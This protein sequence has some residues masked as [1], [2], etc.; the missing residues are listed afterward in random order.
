MPKKVWKYFILSA[1]LL[2]IYIGYASI[3][4]ID[5]K[6][7]KT[8][9]DPW[10][11]I[12]IFI[13]IW[14]PIYAYF[15]NKDD[16]PS[17]KSSS[18]KDNEAASG[19]WDSFKPGSV[20]EPSAKKPKEP[21][22]TPSYK[23]DP[24]FENSGNKGGYSKPNRAA[25]FEPQKES[26]YTQKSH[27]EKSSKN[28]PPGSNQTNRTDKSIA[29]SYK[30]NERFLE[31]TLK[32]K[33]PIVVPPLFR[34]QFIELKKSKE[35]VVKGVTEKKFI[36]FLGRFFPNRVSQEGELEVPGT[37][38][39]RVYSPDAILRFGEINIVI[40]IDE[41]YVGSTRRPTHCINSYDVDRNKVFSE[42][43]WMVVRFAEEQIV[44]QPDECIFFLVD[45]ISTI[46][47]NLWFTPTSMSWPSLVPQWTMAQAEKMAKEGYREKYLG[48]TFTPKE[49]APPKEIEYDPNSD[50]NEKPKSN[51]PNETKF[52]PRDTQPKKE[53]PKPAVKPKSQAKS[54][55]PIYENKD[56]ANPIRPTYSPPNYGNRKPSDKPSSPGNVSGKKSDDSVE[57]K[58]RNAIANGYFLSFTYNRKVGTIKP[59]KSISEEGTVYLYGN[60]FTSNEVRKFKVKKIQT[61]SMKVLRNGSQK[62]TNKDP[63]KMNRLIKRA[64]NFEC[65]ATIVYQKDGEQKTYELSHIDKSDK[66]NNCISGQF[67]RGTYDITL[68]IRKIILMEIIYTSHLY[69][70]YPSF[71]HPKSYSE[72]PKV[73]PT[74]TP[75]PSARRTYK[76]PSS[77]SGCMVFLIV[78][79]S[80]IISLLYLLF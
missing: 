54:S 53:E 69:S 30:V 17:S 80:G 29:I 33:Y 5:F 13:L 47:S 14:I 59:T 65:V 25:S 43:G 60:E 62:C 18:G 67:L 68:S 73:T 56:T 28:K 3:F 20:A 41:P 31:G 46:D 10:I 74:P 27:P 40:E 9:N 44:K 24:K 71:G 8:Y 22:I 48:I 15:F 75:R 21:I 1:V 70:S 63:D 51:L 23:N 52:V 66:Y 2:A 50:R 64:I 61:S 16:T 77:N 76:A 57:T 11:L 49:E 55:S 32:G 35:Y 37:R 19:G 34:S 72:K 7:Y 39:G 38:I 6:T 58:I 45:L 42:N 36:E 12:T 78:G 4:V 79:G 26:P